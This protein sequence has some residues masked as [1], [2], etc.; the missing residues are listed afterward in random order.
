[1]ICVE[2]WAFNWL[3]FEVLY[4]ILNPVIFLVMKFAQLY[5]HCFLNVQVQQSTMV[6]VFFCVHI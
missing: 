2:I 6:G 5:T 1:M 4:F 3:A